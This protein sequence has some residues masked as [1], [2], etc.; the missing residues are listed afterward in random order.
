VEKYCPVRVVEVK[1]ELPEVY[2]SIVLQEED[3][4]YRELRFAIGTPEAV[5]IAA[6]LKKVD[7]PRPMTHDLLS[8]VLSELEVSVELVRIVRQEAG[9]YHAEL[10]LHDSG[11]GRRVIDCRPS[12]AIALAL[13]QPLYVPIVVADELLAPVVPP[14][15]A[16]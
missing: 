4:P 13:R 12:D 8:K 6:A 7:F 10:H 2:P 14:E 16:K 15:Q 9:N 3:P 1:L 5:A 11:G